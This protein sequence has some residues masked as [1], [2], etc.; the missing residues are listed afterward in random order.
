M[1]GLDLSPIGLFLEA[2]LVGK[3][4]MAVL[5]LGLAVVLGADHRGRD[6]GRAPP[7]RGPRRARGRRGRAIAGRASPKRAMRKR[8]AEFRARPSAR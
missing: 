8:T 7:P 3:A 6:F 4:V 5:F 1:Q 2:G